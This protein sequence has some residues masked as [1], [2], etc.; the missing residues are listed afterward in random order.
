LLGYVGT[1]GIEVGFG[2][3]GAAALCIACLG[4]CAGPVLEQLAEFFPLAGRVFADPGGFGGRGLGGPAA[5]PGLPAAVLR[6]RPA[7]RL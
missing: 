7:R 5:W 2:A 1:C 3:L 6:L 4:E